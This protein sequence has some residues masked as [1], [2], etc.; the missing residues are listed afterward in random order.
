MKRRPGAEE[1]ED[2][3]GAC[4]IA[5]PP[6]FWQNIP[7][8]QPPRDG[9]TEQTPGRAVDKISNNSTAALDIAK[10]VEK[11]NQAS[12]QQKIPLQN[13][14]K[15]N[16]TNYHYDDNSNSN[17]NSNNNQS[18]YDSLSNREDDQPSKATHQTRQQTREYLQVHTAYHSSDD[19]T[20]DH[21]DERP[22]A[23]QFGGKEGTSLETP[24]GSIDNGN[25]AALG[26]D[27]ENLVVAVLAPIAVV[28]TAILV[29]DLA[30]SDNNKTSSTWNDR[31]QR[32]G[33]CR[34][35]TLAAVM[36][37][38]VFVTAL[39]VYLVLK[40]QD[41]GDA[42]TTT[43][44]EISMTFAPTESPTV[45]EVFYYPKSPVKPEGET[46]FDHLLFVGYTALDESN[47]D[48]ITQIQIFTTVACVTNND[49][50]QPTKTVLSLVF[51]YLLLNGE[52]KSI[53]NGA[54]TED[55]RV[56]DHI[57]NIQSD[58]FIYGIELLT[59]TWVTHLKIC[60]T[61]GECFGPFGSSLEVEPNVIFSYD[62][63]ATVGCVGG[64]N[65]TTTTTSD[66][67]MVIKAFYGFSGSWVDRL[68]VYYEERR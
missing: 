49:C 30:D 15:N 18:N 31:L 1:D 60:T 16:N 37:T 52:T 7:Q 12:S 22:G 62:N 24:V 67:M 9:S 39:V 25:D 58:V 28:G 47:I 27:T 44:T 43:Q 65:T 23:F 35:L 21:D 4:A 41:S 10:S 8:P 40:Q 46:N 55:G 51:T 42:T 38:L 68:G 11:E 17:S 3:T 29:D 48:K 20:V 2:D 26:R 33:S 45:T 57:V 64:T 54:Y 61:D 19:T 6:Q 63:N 32:S 36:V 34:W 50:S 66:G 14:S 53:T 56:P 59:E 5:A 13:F